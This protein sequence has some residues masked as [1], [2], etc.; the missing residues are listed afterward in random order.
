MDE[1]L[2]K[3]FSRNCV[4]R[5]FWGYIILYLDICKFNIGDKRFLGIQFSRVSIINIYF[6]IRD[7]VIQIWQEDIKNIYIVLYLYEWIEGRKKCVMISLR[8]EVEEGIEVGE[9]QRW[10]RGRGGEGEQRCRVKRM[11][12]N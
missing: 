1:K 12:I 6:R 11:K 3:C 9:R 4:F 7:L 8:R 5:E 2:N 10:G